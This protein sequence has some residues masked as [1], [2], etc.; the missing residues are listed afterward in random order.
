MTRD[1]RE[2]LETLIACGV[3]RVLT[4]GGEQN[5]L[6][7]AEK[8]AQLAAVAA[9][10]ISVMA[11]G[12]VRPENVGQILSTTGVR[13]IHAGLR[14][15]LRSPMRYRNENISMGL[16]AGR[17]YERLVVLEESVRELAR[18]VE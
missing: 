4:S 13:E 16:V 1:L 15:T 5:A 14:S 12:G 17:E 8:I 9:K 6:K 11:G 2:S 18:A 10:R 3:D 7:G